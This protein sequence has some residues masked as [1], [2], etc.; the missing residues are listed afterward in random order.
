MSVAP[1]IVVRPTE[2]RDDAGIV[3]L[4]KA[5]YP[6]TVPWSPAHLA[7][8]REIS[9]DG[10]FVAVTEPDDRVAGMAASLVIRWDDYAFDLNWQQF[11]DKG[12]FTN[13][14]P[15]QGRT[16][17]SA[18]VMVHPD[19]RGAASASGCTPRAGS[20]PSASAC[21]AFAQARGCAATI[22]WRIG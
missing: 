21:C 2:P 7:S 15:V 6:D 11:T 19:L 12:M 3:E 22:A 9:P 17:Y 1:N 5:V 18:E 8:H 16:L 13:H 4:T 20:S 10:Q 14:D